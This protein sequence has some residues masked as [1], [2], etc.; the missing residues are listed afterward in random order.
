MLRHLE[1][2]VGQDDRTAWPADAVAVMNRVAGRAKLAISFGSDGAWAFEVGAASVEGALGRLVVIVADAQTDGTWTRLKVCASDTCRW[3]FYDTSRAGN[4]KWCSM[5]LC[6][7]RAKQEA[8]RS[9]V[10]DS[11]PNR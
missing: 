7:N 1:I 9:R 3:A 11:S 6:G 4:G 8:W 10:M 5:R 2:E